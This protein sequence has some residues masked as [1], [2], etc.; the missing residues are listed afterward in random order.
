MLLLNF[1]HPV[2]D[3]Q[4]ESLGKLIGVA[5]AR[6]IDVPAQFDPGRPFAEQVPPL[7][8]AVPLNKADWQTEPFVVR[9]PSF[10]PLAAVLLAE[11]YG[12]CGFFPT[13]VRMRPVAGASAVRYEVTEVIGL[14]EVRD[15]AR[16]RR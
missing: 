1:G 12:R 7:V 3:E 5:V 15:A 8:D 9:L 16:G 11:L 2:T 13:V 14:Q 10:A 4:R 6:V